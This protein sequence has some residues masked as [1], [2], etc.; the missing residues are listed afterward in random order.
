VI[1]DKLSK[2]INS[3]ALSS[4]LVA[5]CGATLAGY[6]LDTSDKSQMDVSN[7]HAKLTMLSMSDGTFASSLLSKQSGPNASVHNTE[8][9]LLLLNTMHRGIPAKVHD[10]V[11]KLLQKPSGTQ[12][13]GSYV[14][15]PHLFAAIV[16]VGDMLPQLESTTVA[17][18]G[19]ALKDILYSDDAVLLSLAMQSLHAITRLFK[20]SQPVFLQRKQSGPAM[21]EFSAH[22]ILGTTM[23][24]RASAKA[25][26]SLETIDVDGAPLRKALV[27]TARMNITENLL[28]FD[29]SAASAAPL[30]VGRY[31]AQVLMQFLGRNGTVKHHESWVRGVDATLT[32]VKFGVQVFAK[33]G[34]KSP[35]PRMLPVVDEGGLSGQGA[36]ADMDRGDSA[37]HLQF[38]VRRSDKGACFTPQQVEA[39]VTHAATQRAL[40]YRAFADADDNCRFTAVVAFKEDVAYFHRSSGRYAVD[41]LVGD[42][43]LN[44]PIKFFLGVVDMRFT[45]KPEPVLPVYRQSLLHASNVALKPLPEI[46]AA[47]RPPV[48]LAEESLSQFFTVA[49]AVP[50]LVLCWYYS[51]FVKLSSG[52]VFESAF[53]VCMALMGAVFVLCWFEAPKFAFFDT[54]VYLAVLG[55]LLLICGRLLIEDAVCDSECT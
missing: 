50:L 41:V 45:Q 6:M 29:L 12:S 1:T 25:V 30:P 17:T 46:S 55:T 24:L 44:Q 13:L 43:R 33:K 53:L 42:A 40:H 31:E 36:V 23:K 28:R 34:K 48:Q 14:Y 18:I 19:A 3:D 49:A 51:R 4:N 54:L 21:I 15:A 20:H 2:L 26:F 37:F 38:R 8:V 22:N 5:F 11:L 16:T 35:G 10:N 47:V 32:D 52:G 9:V 27:P 39:R 7:L